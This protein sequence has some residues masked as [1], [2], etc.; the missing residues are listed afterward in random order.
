MILLENKENST[1]PSVVYPFGKS[2]D[3]TGSNN[4]TPLN[5]ATLED[6]HQFFAKMF[7][8]SGLTSNGL[9]DNFTNGFQLFEAFQ[10]S[11]RPYKVYSALITQVGTSDPTI[12]VL[13]N[14]IGNIIWTR[15]N[16]GQYLGTLTSS[17]ISNKTF[18]HL[19]SLDSGNPTTI[20]VFSTSVVLISSYSDYVYT[21]ADGILSKN[22]IEI[23]VYN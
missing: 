18:V 9:P 3:N 19:E 14:T 1:A 11:S 2:T 21:S 13:E 15:N 12:T 6:Y 17:F 23:R 20:S 4:G 5:S 16:V 7:N 8:Y 10:R 22:P